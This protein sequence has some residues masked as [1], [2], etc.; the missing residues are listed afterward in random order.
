MSWYRKTKEVYALRKNV[1]RVDLHVHAGDQKDFTDEQI[2]KSTIKSVLSAGIIKGLDVMG[3][4]AHDGPQIGQAA[5]EIAKNEGIDLWVIA[6][7][8]Y[9]CSDKVRIIAYNLPQALPANMDYKTA[10][11]YVHKNKGLVMAV[12][13]TRRQAQM[14]NRLAETSAAPDAIELYNAAVGWYMDLD[15]DAKYQNFTNSAAKNA[16]MLEDTNVY[17]L[18]SRKDFEKLGFMPPGA[19]TEYVPKYLKVQ[20]IQENPGA[21]GV[22]ANV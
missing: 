10:A 2:K 5:I 16:K 11:E 12:D 6:G 20:D 4:V 14:I 21:Q 8:E 15:I 9:I 18:I 19:G 22:P 17:T 7:Q 1:L 13:I 3:I